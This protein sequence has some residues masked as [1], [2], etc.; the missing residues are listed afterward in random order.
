VAIS[1][2]GRRSLTT[3]FI[4]DGGLKPFIEAPSR[5]P[6][7]T[8]EERAAYLADIATRTPD[9]LPVFHL[10]MNTGA[11]IGEVMSRRVRDV[12]FGEKLACIDYRRTKT[13]TDPR[14]VPLHP[15]YARGLR[16][17]IAK[18][19]LKL[20]DKLLASGSSASVTGWATRTYG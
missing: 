14:Q 1:R 2:A 16:E 7:L 20:N 13:D 17:H 12:S 6:D 15:D 9:F 10:L 8:S 11:D 3:H 4:K 5:L 18:H 19:H